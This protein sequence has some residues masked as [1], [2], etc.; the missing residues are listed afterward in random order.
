[1]ILVRPEDPP[2]FS[3]HCLKCSSY[4]CKPLCLTA[5]ALDS[6]Q[7]IV[8]VGCFI[9]CG[10]AC[11]L[12]GLNGLFL[13]WTVSN[14]RLTKQED[15]G[16]TLCNCTPVLLFSTYVQKWMRLIYFAISIYKHLLNTAPMLKHLRKR[17]LNYSSFLMEISISQYECYRDFKRIILSTNTYRNIHTHRLYT[18]L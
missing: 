15:R 11:N 13:F 12:L 16:S 17:H 14:N 10:C 4:V 1:M 9:N 8:S 3:Q 2:P 6:P 7:G 5:M 18:L